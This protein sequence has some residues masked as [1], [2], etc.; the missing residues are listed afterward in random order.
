MPL[1]PPCPHDNRLPLQRLPLFSSFPL[2][3][4]TRSFYG[5]FV[6]ADDVA[7]IRRIIAN[8]NLSLVALGCAY[9]DVDAAPTAERRRFAPLPPPP[10]TFCRL[11]A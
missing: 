8:H 1:F 10:H 3:L 2:P 11:P 6:R 9:R 4:S 5:I 7:R